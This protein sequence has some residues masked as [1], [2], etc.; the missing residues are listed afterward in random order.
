MKYGWIEVWMNRSSMAEYRSLIRH[1]WMTIILLL[2]QMWKTMN[3]NPIIIASTH[4]I[5]YK[6]SQTKIG[7][8]T[9]PNWDSHLIEMIIIWSTYYE[10][11]I[12][13]IAAKNKAAKTSLRE[14]TIDSI[15]DRI[16]M[17]WQAT[18][19]PQVKAPSSIESPRSVKFK[20]RIYINTKWLNYVQRAVP[21]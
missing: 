5:S 6:L 13:P 16:A 4:I 1:I 21:S 7:S 12:L 19:K 17:G 11:L 3:F 15:S 20:Q 9:K 10:N 18:I 8:N 2:T 14:E